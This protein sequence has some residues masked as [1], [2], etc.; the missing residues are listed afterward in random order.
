MVPRRFT[1]SLLILLCFVM[2]LPTAHAYETAEAT[3]QAYLD[4][5]RDGQWTVMVALVTSKDTRRALD[6]M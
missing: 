5:F 1:T 4:Y 2:A 3:A 6:V